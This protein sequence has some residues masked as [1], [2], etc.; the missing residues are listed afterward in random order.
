[1]PK[2]KK[3]PAPKGSELKLESRTKLKTDQI[4]RDFKGAMLGKSK[5]GAGNKF[6]VN[7]DTFRRTSIKEDIANQR[8]KKAF[9]LGKHAKKK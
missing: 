5:L 1:M 2:R 6:N 8:V 9:Q 7:P 3:I 4:Q